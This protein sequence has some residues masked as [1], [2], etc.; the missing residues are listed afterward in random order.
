[1][2]LQSH[3]SEIN[4]LPCLPD[5][6]PDGSVS[7]LMARGGHEVSIE[8]KNGKLVKTKI[9]SKLGNPIKVR[10]GAKVIEFP[11]ESGQALILDGSLKVESN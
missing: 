9:I 5:K 10:Y 6:L 7:G 2:L 3:A 1:M 11:V 4:L 8:W